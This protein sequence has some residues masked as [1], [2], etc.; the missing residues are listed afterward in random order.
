MTLAEG[1]LEPHEG[2][3]ELTELDIVEETP[4]R[5]VRVRLAEGILVEAGQEDKTNL[6]FTELVANGTQDPLVAS[7]AFTGIWEY[8]PADAP[9]VSGELLELTQDGTTV[10]GCLGPVDITG[11][12]NG[13][14]LRASG[15]DS[16]DE[17]ESV[18]IL[19]P[20]DDGGLQ[21]VASVNGGR[22]VAQ[23]APVAP[24][25]STT[26]CSE[27]VVEAPVC[28]SVVYVNF[29]VNSAEIRAESE[30]VLDDLFTRLEA[31]AGT[32]VSIEGHTSTEGD[33]A[34]NL[35]LSERRAQ[36]VV[37]ALVGR[38]LD[39]GTLSAVGMG[40]SRPLVSPDDDESARSLN[41]RVEIVCA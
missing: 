2:D 4:V 19:L 38:G 9:D 17:R 6:E 36:A 31:E 24:A 5:W 41:R 25:D 32:A 10:T 27:E 12:V 7:E 37:D 18:Y 21:G 28:G 29:D 39:E 33:E 14:I 16:R 11:T 20:L 26:P 30:P 23:I 3:V 40:E 35:D 34:Y 1:T 15:I 8:K 22:F 13:N